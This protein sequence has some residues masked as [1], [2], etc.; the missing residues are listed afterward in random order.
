MKS[1]EDNKY[2]SLAQLGILVAGF[3]L[4]VIVKW[5]RPHSLDTTI[6]TLFKSTR[7]MLADACFLTPLRAGIH[8]CLH[9][10]TWTCSYRRKQ[11]HV[12]YALP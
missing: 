1:A 11:T 10:L 8:L 4:Q 7:K 2:I 3:Q 5:I 6:I 9:D 12:I